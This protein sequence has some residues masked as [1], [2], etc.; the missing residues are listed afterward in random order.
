[1]VG[2]AGAVGGAGRVV[3]PPVVYVPCAAVPEAG[4]ADRGVVSPDAEVTVEFR[5][6]A[7]GRT[8]LLAYTALDRLV[9]C[10]GPYQPWILMPTAKLDE[11]DRYLRYDLI[12]LDLDVPAEFRRRGG[13]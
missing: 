9:D 11:I 1:M 10:C 6:T 8:A 13:E 4:V 2:A 3:V 7:D 5:R 12:L